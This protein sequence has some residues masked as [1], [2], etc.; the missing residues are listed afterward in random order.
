MPQGIE[1]EIFNRT[2]LLLGEETVDRIQR[3]RIIIFGVG[4]VGSWCA[5]GLV[6]SG[7]RNLTIV[8]SDVV[9]LSNVNRQLMATVDTVGQVKVEAL[10][11]RLLSINPAAE[12]ATVHK[13]YSE[14]TAPLFDLE[15]YDYVVD[16]ID[17]LKSKIHLLLN[18]SALKPKLFCSMGAALK[19]DAQQVRV[20]EFWDVKGCPL[21]AAI[22]K[23]M[24]QAKVSPKK[25]FKCVYSAEVLENKG[26]TKEDPA[27]SGKAVING[28]TAHVTAVFGFTLSGLILQD[29]I[30]NHSN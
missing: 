8:D 11:D 25:K 5:E 29:I 20:A 7:I 10:R 6:R 26:F 14:E 1:K 23:K 13:V 30:Q 2:S 22:R 9:N 3:K 12:I 18:A 28:T 17:T 19:I 27:A 24:R 4:G 21:A 16:C 15:Q